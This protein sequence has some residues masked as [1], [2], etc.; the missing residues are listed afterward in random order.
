MLAVF[1]TDQV[2]Q[3]MCTGAG[4]RQGTRRVAVVFV[5]ALIGVAMAACVSRGPSTADDAGQGKVVHAL[6]AEVAEPP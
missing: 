1:K 6:A 2:G 5:G 4:L 3:Q